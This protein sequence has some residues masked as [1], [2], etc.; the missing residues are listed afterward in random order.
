MRLRAPSIG[1]ILSI[2]SAV[3]SSIASFAAADLPGVLAL[4]AAGDGHV[5]WVVKSEPQPG[6]PASIPS[7]A[8]DFV[9]MHHG[10]D[11]PAPSERLVMRFALEPQAIAAEDHAWWS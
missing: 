3:V 7:K 9:L 11:E 2:A 4:S 5:W 8:A 6:D 1:V 10:V